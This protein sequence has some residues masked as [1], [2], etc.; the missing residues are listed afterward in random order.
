M[1]D[2]KLALSL[3]TLV[4]NSAR[5]LGTFQVGVNKILWGNGNT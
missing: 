3:E 4:N 2:S 1:G 5:Q